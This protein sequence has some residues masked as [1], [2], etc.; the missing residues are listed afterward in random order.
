VPARA[1]TLPRSVPQTL[2]IPAHPAQELRGARA[3]PAGWLVHRLLERG[4]VISTWNPSDRRLTPATVLPDRGWIHVVAPSPPELERLAHELALPAELLAHGLDVDEIAR[5]D[6]DPGG[7]TLAVV[8]IPHHENGGSAA[9]PYRSI[10]VGVVTRG[11][12]IVTLAGLDT[13]LLPEL[14]RSDRFTLRPYGFVLHLVFA[15]AAQFMAEL[16]IIQKTV[17]ALQ[18][19]LERALENREVLQLV[20]Q[21]KALVFFT[22]ALRSNELMLE[23]LSKDGH[24]QLSAEDHELLEDVLVEVRQAIHVTTIAEEIL[25]QM[26]DAFASIVSNNLNVVMKVL[27]SLTLIF[28]LPNIVASFY[29]MNVALPGQHHP[30]AFAGTVL[31][32][33]VMGLVVA[34]LF[35]RRRWL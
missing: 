26:M 11:E 8:R 35:I 28:A 34:V 16:R 3:R 13:P 2:R 33:V 12:L 24:A 29:G 27:T 31:F 4:S 5:I 18:A 20:R 32:A 6:H 9:F 17:D 21:Q 19:R 14:G 25:S 23:R 22:T 10:A 7:A 1:L 30:W 15:A